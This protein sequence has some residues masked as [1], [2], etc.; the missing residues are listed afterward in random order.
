MTKKKKNLGNT[1]LKYMRRVINVKQNRCANLLTTR[2]TNR[3]PKHQDTFTS[4]FLLVLFSH[5]HGKI[6]RSH[7][8]FPIVWIP[9]EELIK[10]H[11]TTLNVTAPL[12]LDNNVSYFVYFCSENNSK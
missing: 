12:H 10:I 3:E 6:F 2:E 5:L 9:N 7:A 11:Q 8:K 1:G 4:N